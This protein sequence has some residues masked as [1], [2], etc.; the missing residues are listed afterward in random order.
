MLAAIGWDVED[1]DE[2][3]E[4]RKQAADS[5]VD[6]A[7][8]LSRTPRLFVEAKALEKAIDIR[9]GASQVLGYATMVGVEWC[10]LTNGDEYLL[11][12][13]HAPV[14]VD[15]KLFRRF[16][17]CDATSEPLALDTL[18]L[19]SRD[20]LREKRLTALWD[21]YYVDRQV[22]TGIENLW[23]SPD[24]GLVRLIRKHAKGLTPRQIKTSLERGRIHVDFPIDALDSASEKPHTYR[25]RKR[26]RRG[27]P[28]VPGLPPQSQ[29]EIP[30]LQA[31]LERDGRLELRRQFDEVAESGV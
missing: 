6:Y 11:Y 8:C 25:H 26:G 9:R 23:K 5:P 1:P 16:S 13:S 18:D 14:D 3:R 17:I 28:R 12:N 31:I 4:Y 22:K 19:L 20:M 2:V 7:L 30:L 29:I 27:S 24:P 15:E 21:A 10:V